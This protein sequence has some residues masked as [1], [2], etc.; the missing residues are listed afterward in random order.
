MDNPF[1]SS[2]IVEQSPEMGHDRAILID[3]RDALVIVVADGSGGQS[4]GGEAAQLVIDTVQSKLTDDFIV[5]D[6]GAWCALLVDL[7]TTLEDNPIAGETT[8]IV[9]AISRRFIAG[10]SV[11]DSRALH[12]TRTN[13]RDLTERQNRRPLLGSGGA[14]PV[15]FAGP[16]HIGSVLVG[17]DGLFG[18][19]NYK[20]LKKL[21]LAKSPTSLRSENLLKAVQLPSGKYCDDV[22]FC[23]IDTI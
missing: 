14:I 8:A 2:M 11:G 22:S 19:T 6:K 10:A 13:V 23:L 5:A 16:S 15:P 18:Y 20:T 4:G 1:E 12:F 17:T 9:M 21:A 7:D 3:H